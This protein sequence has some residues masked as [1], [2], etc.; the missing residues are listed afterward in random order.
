MCIERTARRQT[1]RGLSLIELLIF[2]VIVGIALAGV[3]TVLR[4]TSAHS[5][6]PMVRKQ[7]LTIA[8]GLLEEVEM[9]PFTVCDPTDANATTATTTAGC[10][11]KIQ[12]F[13]QPTGA[14][15]RGFFNNV[16]NYCSEVGTGGATCS[17][18]ALG[19]AGSATSTIPNLT[20]GSSSQAGYSATISLTPEALGGIAS[21]AAAAGMNVLRIKVTV[22]SYAFPENVVLEGYR[23]RWAPHL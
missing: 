6:D 10:A 15:N 14:A 7:M 20:G 9:Q 5:A 11:T 23:T 13:G 8:E 21:V 18:L 4:M 2:I 16:G 19:T 12:G 17:T 22:S 1:Q 3:I